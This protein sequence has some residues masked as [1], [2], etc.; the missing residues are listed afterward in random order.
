MTTKGIRMGEWAFLLPAIIVGLGA[1]VAFGALGA[2]IVAKRL[3]YLCGAVAHASVGGIGVALYA[4]DGLG[5]GWVDPLWGAVLVATAA[6]LLMEVVRRWSPDRED[7]LLSALWAAGMSIGL[8]CLAFTPGYANP[9]DFLF[10]NLLLVSMED[11]GRVLAI[12]AVIL[13][14]LVAF[15]PQWQAASFDEEFARLRGVRVELFS[16]LLMVLV[17][18]TVVLLMAVVGLVLIVALMVL[19]AAT[20]GRF[21][22][23]LG[24][25]MA[26]GVAVCALCV[27]GGM[28]VSFFADWPT[29]P[30]IV[31]WAAALYLLASLVRR[32]SS[33]QA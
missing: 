1:S 25:M 32:R 16:A 15:F 2:V 21:T 23:S 7:T 33:R 27:I 24:A 17:S 8:V 5:W 10:G 31:L 14:V 28:G 9:S 11:V 30:S 6:G 13:L 3:A 18:V 20:A 22:R 19:P 26:G 12:D 29:G 4:R